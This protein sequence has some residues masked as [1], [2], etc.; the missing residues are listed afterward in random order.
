[1]K[2]LAMRNPGIPIILLVALAL[3]GTPGLPA[4]DENEGKKEPADKKAA[5]DSMAREALDK[6]LAGTP[7][8]RSAYEKAYGY[9]VFDNHKVAFVVSGGGGSGVAVDKGAG[10]RTYMKMGT[11][12]VGLG[13]GYKKYQVVF[14]F[15]TREVFDNFVEK[16]WKAETQASAAAG[17]AGAG[18]GS[19][20]TNGIATYQL[21][22]KG[23]MAQA[24]I[25]GTKFW[26]D[27]DLNQ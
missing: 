13:L 18:A 12:G 26:K 17:T 9:A 14:L 10:K 5:I 19:T 22:E 16:G 11:G 6:V 15:E 4:G 27:E 24:D 23:L 21:T 20:F 7:H 8:A 1:M 25:A 3:A 2:G